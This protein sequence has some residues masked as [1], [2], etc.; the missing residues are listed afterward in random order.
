[1]RITFLAGAVILSAITLCGSLWAAAPDAAEKPYPV[2]PVAEWSGK[3]LSL[4]DCKGQI[5]LVVFFN[6]SKG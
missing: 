1:M 5:L 4:E 3:P 2:L 6:D